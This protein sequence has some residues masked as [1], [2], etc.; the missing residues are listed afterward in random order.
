MKSIAST[1]SAFIIG[2]TVCA[3]LGLFGMS[4]ANAQQPNAATLPAATT[5]CT[6]V[7][8]GV[9]DTRIHVRCSTAVSGILYFAAPTSN[10]NRAA[11]LL[12]ILSTAVAASHNLT[13]YYDPADTSGS[14]IGCQTS[15]CRLI[16][17]VELL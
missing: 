12:A 13:I 7:N 16:Q 8:V 15:D 14:S 5:V 2:A 9:F 17:S 11:R 6:P 1:R 4:G 3:S 10:N